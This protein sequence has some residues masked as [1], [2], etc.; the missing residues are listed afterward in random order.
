[1]NAALLE[2]LVK[3]VSHRVQDAEQNAVIEVGR[4]YGLTDQDFHEL[5]RAVW[6]EIRKE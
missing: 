5:H 1:M 6:K 3:Y 2:L 4:W